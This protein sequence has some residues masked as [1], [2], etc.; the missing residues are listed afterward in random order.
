MA[1]SHHI[2]LGSSGLGQRLRLSLFLANLAVLRRACQVFVECP[3]VGFCLMRFSR[4]DWGGGRD[5]E[6]DPR[7]EVPFS[8]RPIRGARCHRDLALLML[9][10][11]PGRRLWL[12]HRVPFPFLLHSLAS[13]APSW[14][15]PHG[16]VRFGNAEPVQA[17]HTVGA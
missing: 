3:L 2:P 11:V 4:L 5:W 13:W 15:R 10:L 8:P 16:T 1:L 7:G 12:P 9:T 17:R 6:E 14:G